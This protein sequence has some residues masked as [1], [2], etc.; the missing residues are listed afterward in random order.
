MIK[1]LLGYF[2]Y[3]K[4]LGK[5]ELKVNHSPLNYNVGQSFLVHEDRH[6]I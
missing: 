5:F 4:N 2:I 6:R 3:S 1:C